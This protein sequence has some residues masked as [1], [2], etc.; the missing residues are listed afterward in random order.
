LQKKIT[1]EFIK[2]MKAKYG[3]GY[4]KICKKFLNTEKSSYIKVMQTNIDYLQSQIDGYKNKIK[5]AE[6]MYD[7][8]T[9]GLN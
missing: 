2:F 7:E 3:K 5:E 4:S 8:N 9:L 6:E 1:I